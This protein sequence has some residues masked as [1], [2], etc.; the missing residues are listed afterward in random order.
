[1]Y[2]VT[3]DLY[4]CQDHAG[5]TKGRHACVYLAGIQEHAGMTTAPAQSDNPSRA[6]FK[7]KSCQTGPPPMAD[8]GS[9]WSMPLW[10]DQKSFSIY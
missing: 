9:L 7:V 1:M 5:M 4:P 3:G 6:S 10:D 8:E 2:P